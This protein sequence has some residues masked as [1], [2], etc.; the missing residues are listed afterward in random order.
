L[1]AKRNRDGERNEREKKELK[2]EAEIK[3]RKRK[4][5]EPSIS[6]SPS[7]PLLLH[8]LPFLQFFTL[9]LPSSLPRQ[10]HNR[11]KKTPGLTNCKE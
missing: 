4:K 5:K 9:R 6:L 7:L 10:K 8:E 11:K 3:K 2:E 1:K